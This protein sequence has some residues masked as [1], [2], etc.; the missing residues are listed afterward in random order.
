MSNSILLD[1]NEDKIIF[2]QIVNFCNSNNVDIKVKSIFINNIEISLVQIT[3]DEKIIKNKKFPVY[4]K[5]IN[6]EIILNREVIY[7]QVLLQFLKIFY[8]VDV[9]IICIS[10]NNFGFVLFVLLLFKI[11]KKNNKKKK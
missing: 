5:Y 3:I 11:K 6:L 2:D 7:Q 1:I 10:K 4:A 9:K 8:N